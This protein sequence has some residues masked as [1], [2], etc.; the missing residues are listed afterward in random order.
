MAPIT[1]RPMLVWSKYV[2]P[3]VFAAGGL[4]LL[5]PRLAAP[6]PGAIFSLLGLILF[7]V[8][9]TF[10]DVQLDERG[11]VARDVVIPIAEIRSYSLRT[12]RGM[13]TLKIT[14]RGGQSLHT[15]IKRC[16]YREI[17]D[18]LSHAVTRQH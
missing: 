9:R 3:A 18:L 11:F 17:S 2:A 10:R 12:G 6:W 5:T 14:S 4:L 1:D 15:I 13:S 16:R 8:N 7:W